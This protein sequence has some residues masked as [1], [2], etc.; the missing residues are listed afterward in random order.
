MAKIDE[1]IKVMLL[2]GE[3]GA[4]I[5]SIDKTSTDGL[6]DTYTVTLTDGTKSNFTVTNGKDGKD[7]ADFDTFEIGGRNLMPK[8]RTFG[9]FQGTAD[10]TLSDGILSFGTSGT[11]SSPVSVRCSQSAFAFIRGQ[12]VTLSFWFRVR[13]SLAT[14]A[15]DPF[16]G[17]VLSVKYSD[18]STQYGTLRIPLTP[19]FA[20]ADSR[21]KK[22]YATYQL[23]DIELAE[24]NVDIYKRSV[25]GAVDFTQPKLE[26]GTKPSDWTPAPE[27]K[28]DVSALA[29]KADV[30][31]IVPKASVESSTTASQ[32]YAAGQYVVVNGILRKVTSAI[33]KGNTIGD[34]NSASTTI[35]GELGVLSRKVNTTPWIYLYDSSYGA[36]RY[37]VHL[38]VLYIRANVKGFT[39]GGWWEAGVL[40]EGYRPKTN[41]YFPMTVSNENNVAILWVGDSGSVQILSRQSSSDSTCWALVAIPLW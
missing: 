31:A 32:A 27:D 13:E 9:D 11:I 21:W 5:K 14:A 41:C 39:T 37:T 12:K 19:D 17:A 34:S 10:I 23:N 30:S 8:S 16:F 33:A 18:G 28:A 26:I 15:D 3:T 1:H 38:D 22:Q 7:G 24:L 29:G 2:K 36:V 25:T 6:V 20:T 40:P 4:N 35:A